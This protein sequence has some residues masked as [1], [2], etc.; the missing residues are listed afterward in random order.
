MAT[1]LHQL[2]AASLLL[3]FGAGRTSVVAATRHYL[4][5]IARFNGALNAYTHVDA[6]GALAAAQESAARY[7]AGKA[8]PLEG[9]PI[10]VKANLAVR[11]L[12]THAGIAALAGRVAPTDA[13]AVAALRGAGAVILGLTNMHEAALG[14][15]TDNLHFGRTMNPHREG[16]TPG[17]SSG[18]SGAAVAAG[19]AAAALGTDTLGSIRIPAAWCGI[20]GLKPS[21]GLVPTG[22]L[23]SLVPRLDCVGPMA[24]SAGDCALL[25]QAMAAPAPARPLLRVARLEFQSGPELDHGVAAALRLSASL[26]EG[27]GHEVSERQVRIDH[28][29][30]RLA[31]FLEAARGAGDLFAGALAAHPQGFSP[32]FHAAVGYAGSSSPA[33]IA[34][35]AR[36]MEATANELQA[37]LQMADVLLLPTTPQAAFPFESEPPQTLADFTAPANLAGLP[38]L[39]LPAGW[40]ESGLPVGI[41]LIGRAGEDLSVLALGAQLEAALNAWRPPS[42]FA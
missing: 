26:L 39:S 31:S 37:V 1:G 3:A 4:D 36:A 20:T 6:D 18:G 33:T 30:V 15:T 7:Q 11:G 34:E 35:G 16:H 10:A 5:R 14:A 8:R 12:P 23:V 13:D 24:R 28:P 32:A 21:N 38:A 2:G 19:L 9:L 42:D 22:G 41:Q 17:G 40:T 25:L 27:L 29:K